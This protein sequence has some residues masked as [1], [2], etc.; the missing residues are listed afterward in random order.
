METKVT[1]TMKKKDQSPRKSATFFIVQFVLITIALLTGYRFMINTY[2]ND[3]YLFTVTEHTAWA[4]DIVGHSTKIQ[5]WSTLKAKNPATKRATMAAWRRGEDQPTPEAIADTPTG[6]LSAWERY[7]FD[8]LSARR[9]KAETPLGPSV[10]FIY[11]AGTQDLITE[12]KEKIAQL[13][14]DTLIAPEQRDSEISDLEAEI[15]VLNASRAVSTTTPNAANADRSV[16]AMLQIVSECG[17]IELFAIFFAAVMAFPT[18]FW[19]RAFGVIVGIPLL[20]CLNIFRLFCLFLIRAWDTD[21]KVFHFV[22][23]YIWQTVYIV[24]VLAL[25]LAWMEYLVRRKTS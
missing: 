5:M 18:P 4:L 19:K 14:Q 11:K 7:S 24:F 17:A 12:A 10:Y 25:W 8:A 6:P 23:E 21:G 15:R 13:R 16:R 22:H 20:Y 3:W 9:N 1:I 2:Y